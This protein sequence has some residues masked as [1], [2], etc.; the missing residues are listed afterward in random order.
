MTTSKPLTLEILEANKKRFT[1][2]QFSALKTISLWPN[3]FDYRKS[4]ESKEFRIPYLPS[5]RQQVERKLALIGLEI[6]SI[7]AND[8]TC[9]KLY[10]LRPVIKGGKQ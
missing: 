10:A 2:K 6:L 4:I 8:G 7:P 1:S 5:F 3:G 9:C